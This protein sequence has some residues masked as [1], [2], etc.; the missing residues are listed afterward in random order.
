MFFFYFEYPEEEKLNTYKI[1]YY[2][3]AREKSFKIN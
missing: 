2:A 1:Y 3:I